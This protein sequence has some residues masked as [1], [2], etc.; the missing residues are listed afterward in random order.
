MTA[1]EPVMA[2]AMAAVV[3]LRFFI[4]DGNGGAG[5]GMYSASGKS[6]IQLNVALSK[7]SCPSC[8]D[9]NKNQTPSI[10]V[11]QLKNCD[12]V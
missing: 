7:I 9:K 3:S 5:G 11:T 12:V 8:V 1:D 6:K 10:S 4:Y 2:V